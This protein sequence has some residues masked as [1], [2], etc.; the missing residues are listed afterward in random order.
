MTCVT[1]SSNGD[2]QH[3]ESITISVIVSSGFQFTKPYYQEVIGQPITLT[4]EADNLINLTQIQITRGTINREIALITMTSQHASIEGVIIDVHNT[5]LQPY[6][7]K[8]SVIIQNTT[9][10][11]KDKFHCKAAGFIANTTVNLTRAA[12]RPTLVLSDQIVENMPT[13]GDMM[14]HCL[15]QLGDRSRTI[16]IESDINGTFSSMFNAP[17]ELGHRLGV[18]EYSTADCGY[19]VRRNFEFNKINMTLDGLR[20]RCVIH[21]GPGESFQALTSDEKVIHVVPANYCSGK[22]QGKKLPHVYFCSLFVLCRNEGF[23]SSVQKCP[24]GQCFSPTFEECKPCDQA[25]CTSED[26]AD[27]FFAK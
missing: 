14:F 15:A 18:I 27:T 25:G 6:A 22:P 19:S 7:G 5:W 10:A 16:D 1:T 23:V 3:G 21:P 24:D 8:L 9:C 26:S 20:L 17:N 2:E 4:C 11:D 13:W 12:E